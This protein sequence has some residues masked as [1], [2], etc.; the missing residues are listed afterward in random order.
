MFDFIHY[1]SNTLIR[2]NVLFDKT[3]P[4]KLYNQHVLQQQL[5][6]KWKDNMLV[7]CVFIDFVPFDVFPSFNDHKQCSIFV[8]VFF[9][10]TNLMTNDWIC[11]SRR[12]KRFWVVAW[13]PCF[14]LI[15]S[16]VLFHHVDEPDVQ[17]NTSLQYTIYCICPNQSPITYIT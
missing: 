15:L 7:L 8:I 3:S 4:Y 6:Y 1:I 9:F 5:Y 16:L 2:V 11:F 13:W 10:F 12:K 14:V 17:Q